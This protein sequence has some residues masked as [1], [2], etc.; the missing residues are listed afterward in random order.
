M[1]PPDFSGFA[2]TYARARPSYPAA[3]FDHLASLVER[4]DHAWDCATGNG[5][6]AHGLVAHFQRV[7]ATDTS[8]AQIAEARPHPRITF[9]VAPAERS[10][11]PSGSVDLV[12]V[13]A[14]VHWFD[15]PRFHEEVRRV[16]RP[17]GVLAVWSYH[18]AHLD[19]PFDAV[20][21]AFFRDHVSDWFDPGAQLVNERY[22]TLAMPG[23]P[24]PAP[25]FHAEV[26]WTAPQIEQFVR[27]WSATQ[28]YMKVHGDAQVTRVAAE[29]EHVCGGPVVR[30]RLRFP[31]Y[32][33]IAR[34]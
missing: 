17:G 2:D 14:A 6:A 30:R 12:T 7:T 9:A 13:A 10:G 28:A 1:T 16:V 5:Q 15:L 11:I 26:D 24:L 19:P 33:R 23:E 32:M 25:R 31:L 22:E 21:G 8:A 27:S 34:L 3:L 20:L 18:V 4:H 29:L